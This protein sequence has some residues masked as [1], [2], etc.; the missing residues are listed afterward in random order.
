MPN[1]CIGDAIVGTG[2]KTLDWTIKLA[3]SKPNC[4]VKYCDTDSAFI[5]I[6]AEKTKAFMI[7]Y[8]LVHQINS[9]VCLPIKMKFEKVYRPCILA[10]KE[11]FLAQLDL[12]NVHL[13]LKY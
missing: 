11:E 9:C 1:P 8:A 13:L 2:R 10:S 6:S 7:S 5:K 4:Q 12:K 3:N